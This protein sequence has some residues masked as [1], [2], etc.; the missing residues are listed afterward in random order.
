MK[1]AREIKLG[2]LGAITLLIFI[3]GVNFLSGRDIF[4]RQITFYAVY[5]QVG[6]LIESN[7]VRISGVRVGQVDRIYFHPDGSGNVIV[8]CVVDRQMQVPS[9]SVARL[10]S[11]LLGTREIEI[12]LGD[13]PM[14]MQEGDTLGSSA[15]ATIAEE[16]TRQMLPFKNQ[17]ESLLAQVDTVLAVI[18]YTFSPQTRDNIVS[19]IESISNTLNS[20]ESTT[21]MV[22]TVLA[23]QISK[24]SVILSNAESITTNISQN[25]D[26]IN[27]IINNFSAVS[28]T[29]AAAQIGQTFA[30]ASKTM[31]D[32]A[33]VVERINSGEGTMGLLLNDEE[34]YRNLESS[35]QQLE[36]LLQEITA[37]PRKFFN[38]S[39][40]GR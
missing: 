26:A 18:Q 33:Q 10:V 35:S 28:D 19:S 25:N 1:M 32:F 34:L 9:N 16:V 24:L 3:W 2:I 38:I 29:L 17:A 12:I 39:V 30:N 27:N 20:L 23:E 5:E 11:D 15:Q 8:E 14:P 4:T 37:N 6:G 31:E 13:S 40:F 21:Q 22:D 7:P 36:I